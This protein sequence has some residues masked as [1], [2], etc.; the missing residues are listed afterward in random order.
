MVTYETISKLAFRKWQERGCP[1]GTPER[2]WLEAER[3][4]NAR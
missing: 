1:A 2:D 3:E 4:L